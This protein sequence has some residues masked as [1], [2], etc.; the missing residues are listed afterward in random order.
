MVVSLNTH[1]MVRAITWP[2]EFFF[3]KTEYKPRIRPQELEGGTAA[4]E[5]AATAMEE[6][7]YYE[8]YHE[9]E[10]VSDDDDDGTEEE[11]N[12]PGFLPG[13]VRWIVGWALWPIIW[14]L[15]SALLS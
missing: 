9:E 4:A 11:E 8:E 3:G 10:E 7:E 15:R 14:P 13:P 1:L 6:I 5:E 2:L 12:F